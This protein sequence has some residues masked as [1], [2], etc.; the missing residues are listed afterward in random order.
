M[1]LS[2]PKQATFYVA[3]ILWLLG[4]IGY[5]VPAIDQ[6]IVGEAGGLA[7]WLAI[8]GGLVL[9]LGNLMDGF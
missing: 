6:L 2:A 5:F 1:N 7:F 4:L 3:A 9:I 8:L